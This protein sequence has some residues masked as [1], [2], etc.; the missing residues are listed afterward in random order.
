MAVAVAR[1]E[2]LKP[3]SSLVTG[4][5]SGPDFAKVVLYRL[6]AKLVQ[7]SPGVSV[8]TWLDDIVNRA[9]GKPKVVIKAVVESTLKLALGL[10]ELGLKV[11]PKSVCLS[12]DRTVTTA[13]VKA[14]SKQQIEVLPTKAAAGAQGNCLEVDHTGSV[15]TRGRVVRAVLAN[16]WP[17]NSI[18]A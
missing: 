3:N 8:N 2:A 12:N 15:P 10:K 5:R 7:G 16:A 9:Q 4:A 14:L 13:I 17:R 1:A 18:P 11:A 6:M